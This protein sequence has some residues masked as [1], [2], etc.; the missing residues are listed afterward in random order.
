MTFTLTIPDPKTM[1]PGKAGYI[2]LRS[3]IEFHRIH[4]TVYMPEQFNGTEKGD[5]RFSP[6]KSPAGMVIPTIYGAES[7]ECAACEVILRCPDVPPVD[8]KTGLPTFQIVFPADFEHYS[9]SVVRTTVDLNLV[10]V[11]TAGQRKFGVDQNALLAG[12]KSTYP[13]TRAWAEH[14]HAT[15]SAA[16]G[17]YYTSFQ[18]GPKFAIVLFGDRRAA[19]AFSP[20]STRRVADDP[21]RDEIATLARSLSIDYQ[22]V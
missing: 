11:T 10:D 6:I 13:E 1:R 14:I 18:Y 22:D 15:C 7:F 21:C 20:V 5:A 8:L 4:P 2:A 12:P 17:L 19:G 3:G 9:H 16:A